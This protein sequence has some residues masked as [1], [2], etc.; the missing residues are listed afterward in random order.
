MIIKNVMVTTGRVGLLYIISITSQ[1]V[2]RMKRNK[3][4]SKLN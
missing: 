4:N 1:E 3:E 2:E